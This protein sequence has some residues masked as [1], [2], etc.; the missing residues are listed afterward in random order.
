MSHR[1]ELALLSLLPS[2]SLFLPSRL[3][4]L[5]I[6]LVINRLKMAFS[7][8]FFASVDL[9]QRSVYYI[10][11]RSQTKRKKAWQFYFR[12]ARTK[13]KRRLSRVQNVRSRNRSTYLPNMHGARTTSNV[14]RERRVRK[15][16]RRRRRWRISD[17]HSQFEK[18]MKLAKFEY[19]TRDCNTTVTRP[20]GPILSR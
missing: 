18:K 5:S 17:R 7:R 1:R 3:L 6:E 2:L 15:E 10:C 14:S 9:L 4:R 11:I 12:G 8:N 16:R 13:E 20:M 19:C